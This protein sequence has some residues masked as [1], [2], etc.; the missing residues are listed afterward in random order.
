[1]DCLVEY[2]LL[3]TCLFN[4]LVLEIF[5]NAEFFSGDSRPK[6]LLSG[7]KCA[8]TD[9]FAKFNDLLFEILLEAAL[10]LE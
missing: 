8:L 3:A 5:F 1:M 7:S 2:S 10:S 6:D 9:L 4:I